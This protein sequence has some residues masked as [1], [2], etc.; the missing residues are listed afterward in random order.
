MALTRCRG[1]KGEV[2]CPAAHPHISPERGQWENW[3]PTDSPGQPRRKPQREAGGTWQLPAGQAPGQDS[4][5]PETPAAL[6]PRPKPLPYSG[7]MDQP[8]PLAPLGV[9]DE[10]PPCWGPQ[11]PHP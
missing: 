2:H 6:H 5:P 10:R 3:F 7:S 9:L 4:G 11:V 8:L 1:A